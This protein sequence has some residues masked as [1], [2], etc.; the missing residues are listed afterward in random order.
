MRVS[1]NDRNQKKKETY[2]KSRA[3]RVQRCT[4][5]GSTE[6]AQGVALRKEH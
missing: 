2:E 6:G 5:R 1:E 3:W 4:E